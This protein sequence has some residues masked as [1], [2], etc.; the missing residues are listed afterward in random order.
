M[1]RIQ[2]KAHEQAK[3]GTL[4]TDFNDWDAIDEYGRTVAWVAMVSGNLPPGF[5]Q[6]EKVWGNFAPLY[7]PVEGS[8]KI[9]EMESLEELMNRLEDVITQLFTND[10]FRLEV[11]PESDD[12]P[13]VDIFTIRLD[14]E[15]VTYRIEKGEEMGEWRMGNAEKLALEAWSLI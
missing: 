8:I 4:P 6:W 11:K 12:A 9:W 5:N 13:S 1:K 15:T 7:P 3:A 10:S 2:S 14:P